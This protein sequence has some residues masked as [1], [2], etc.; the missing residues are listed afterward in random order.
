MAFSARLVSLT[1][2]MRFLADHI[3]GDVYFKT[4]RRGH[5]LDRARVQLRLVE[6]MERILPAG[7]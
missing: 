4:S 7:H 1:L 6:E 2:A 3:L 5:N